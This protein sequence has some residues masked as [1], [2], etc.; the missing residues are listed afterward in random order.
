MGALIARH[1]ASEHKDKLS[2]LIML[3]SI[4]KRTE[5]QNRVVRSRFEVAKINRLTSKQTA[6]RRWL[7][8]DFLKKNPDIYKKNILN[9]R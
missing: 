4:Y 7:S 9:F 2:S 8:V 1:F 5:E 3:G 6:L